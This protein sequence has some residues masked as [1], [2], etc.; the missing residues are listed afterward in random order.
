MFSRDEKIT[1]SF[2]ILYSFGS[3]HV[4]AIKMARRENPSLNF[5]FIIFYVKRLNSS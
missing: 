4:T 3:V 2:F 1:I 5:I